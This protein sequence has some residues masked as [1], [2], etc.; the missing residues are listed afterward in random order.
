MFNKQLV[1]NE[2]NPSVVIEFINRILENIKG[3]GCRLEK[4]IEREGG[5]KH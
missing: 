1:A 3:I 4:S 2:H 5:P